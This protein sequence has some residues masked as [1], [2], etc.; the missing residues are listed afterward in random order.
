MR[1]QQYLIEIPL[2]GTFLPIRTCKS[3]TCIQA[4]SPLHDNINA[5]EQLFNTIFSSPETMKTKFGPSLA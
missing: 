4:T 3:D 1:Y 2:K 5:E